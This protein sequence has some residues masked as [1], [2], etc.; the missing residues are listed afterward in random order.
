MKVWMRFT[1]FNKT[2]EFGG[3]KLWWLSCADEGSRFTE[4]SVK[5]RPHTSKGLCDL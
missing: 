4:W 2:T 5:G 3:D 1:G